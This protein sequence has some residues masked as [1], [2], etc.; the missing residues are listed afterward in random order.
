M[1][2]AGLGDK[3]LLVIDKSLSPTNDKTWCFW[4]K[5]QPSFKNLINKKWSQSDIFVNGDHYHQRLHQYPYY[6]IRSDNYRSTI[7]GE[8]VEHPNVELLE[9]PVSELSGDEDSA[10]LL[11]E[12]GNF[13]ADFIFQ[14]CFKPSLKRRPRYP[15]IQHFL[16]WEITTSSTIFDTESFI[17]MDF[18]E[19]YPNGLAFMYVLPWSSTSALLEYTIFSKSPEDLSLYEK[20]LELYLHN[21]YGLKRLNY[22]IDRV[23]YGKIPMNDAIHHAW[24]AP[25]VLNLGANAGLTKPSTGYTFRRI[26]EHSREIVNSLIKKG[27]PAPAPRSERRYRNYD[28]WLLQILYDH[29]QEAQEVFRQLFKNNS[30]DDVFRFLGE[31]SNLLEDLKIMSS[32]PWWPFLRAIWKTK[33]SI[34]SF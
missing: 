2:Q 7:I 4:E 12:D 3:R 13:Q 27:V 30:L 5:E 28:L 34:L 9:S 31:E 17:L 18:D 16:G 21:R 33:S 29:P 23:E 22:N 20:K 32:V 10:N 8:L 11:C 24:Y 14:S 15:L 6:S 19:T 1:M 25:R 26:Q